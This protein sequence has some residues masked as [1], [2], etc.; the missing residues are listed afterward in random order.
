[1]K[2]VLA[3]THVSFED[4][5][6]FAGTLEARGFEV[7]YHE[8][9]VERLAP[10]AAAE[11]D[12]VVVMGGPMGAMDDGNYPFL[13]EETEFLERRIEAARPVLGICL[14]AQLIARALGSRV[15]PAPRKEIEW[16][17]LVLA[18]KGKNSSLGHLGPEHTWVLHWHGDTFDLPRGAVGLASTEACP[19]QAFSWGNACLALQ[20]HPEVTAA[21]LERWFVGH[22]GEI[23]TT[24][25]ISVAGLRR[26]TEAW[27]GTL[28]VQGRR[29]LEGWLDQA[30]LG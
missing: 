23:A 12:L 26:D 2:H 11:P 30:G 29:F 13:A 1:M 5:G 10:L 14:G 20:F 24:E 27:A 8:A 22:G 17:P 28:E 21:G 19:N 25:G 4:L 15:Y 3:I 7:N 6:S 18:E 16:A 9:G